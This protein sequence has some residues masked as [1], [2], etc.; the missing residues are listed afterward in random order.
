VFVPYKIFE[1][2]LMSDLSV[3]LE[4]MGQALSVNYFIFNSVD[5]L[6]CEKEKYKGISVELDAAFTEMA[7]F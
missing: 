4:L 7:G 3:I 1:I 5:D 2:S 6:L